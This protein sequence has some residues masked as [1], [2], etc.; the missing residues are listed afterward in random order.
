VHYLFLDETYRDVVD[1]RVIV[2][3]S[4]AVEQGRLN[5]RIHKLNELR[6]QGKASILERIDSTLESLD[7][8]ALVAW[9]RL[10]K[11]LFRPGVIDGT[12][13][14]PA[15]ARPD[16]IWSISIIF[17]VGYL[18]KQVLL[19]R[20]DVGTV[21][22]YFDTRRLRVPHSTALEK[23]LRGILISEGRRFSAQIGGTLLKNLRI[24]RLQPIEKPKN[25]DAPNKFQL[26]T[27]V[28]HKLCSKS[29][30]IINAGG[31][32]RIRTQDMSDVIRRTV[33]QWEGKS[34]Y[35]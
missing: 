29:D 24:R 16:T 6:Q 28:S 3:A 21:D 10:E 11:S 35:E 30:L 23:N 17:V 26:G 31:T 19:R 18:I 2:V 33:Q 14:I 5:D 20:K 7:A 22:V 1:G 15:M 9:A 12:N 32:S 34:F 25:N 4:W 8:L 27:W 13:D